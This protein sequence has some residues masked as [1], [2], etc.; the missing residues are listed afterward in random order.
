M[1]AQDEED[2]QLAIDS[3]KSEKV[4]NDSP[5]DLNEKSLDHTEFNYCLSIHI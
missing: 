2:D 5:T 1:Q 4:S 3:Q